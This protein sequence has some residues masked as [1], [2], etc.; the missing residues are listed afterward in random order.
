MKL[1]ICRLCLQEKQLINKSHI[2]SNFFY[3]DISGEENEAYLI[4]LTTSGQARKVQTGEFEGGLLCEDCDN[5]ILGAYEKYGSDFIFGTQ[6]KNPLN[7]VRAQ[8]QLH[9]DGKLKSTHIIGL[10]YTKLKL[11]ML[12]LLW[13]ASITTRPFFKKISLGKYEEEI[14]LMLLTNSPGLQMKFPTMISV[15]TDKNKE[16]SEGMISSPTRFR[17]NHCIAYQFQIGQMIFMYFVSPK[18][19]ADYIKEVAINEDGE[20]RIPH[21][22]GEVADKHMKFVLGGPL[23]E[24]YMKNLTK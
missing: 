18:G 10:D 15:I 23:H 22:E 2:L 1:G 24:H 20:M 3:R 9:P 6:A 17:H 14:R 7:N 12:S 16:V 13:R 21:L 5:R 11:F 4:P 19:V 8:D